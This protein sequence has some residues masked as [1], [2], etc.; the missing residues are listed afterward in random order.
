MSELT[1][2][3]VNKYIRIV[4]AS[5]C[6]L[7]MYIDQP[8]DDTLATQ[9]KN[10]AAKITEINVANSFEIIISYASLLVSYNPMNTDHFAVKNTIKS[11]IQLV[12]ESATVNKDKAVSKDAVEETVNTVELPVYYSTE[13]GPDLQR[14]AEHH[15]LTV[16]DVIRLHQQA[17]YRVFAIGFAPGFGYLGQVSEQIAMPR[18]S[19]PRSQV[20]KGAV[21]IADRQTAVYPAT[22]P[23]GWNIIGQCPVLMFDPTSTQNLVTGESSKPIMPFKVGDSVRFYAIDKQEYLALGGQL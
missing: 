2:A 23:G 3:T 5:E 16:E 15:N 1:L 12:L 13:C 20:P 11:A 17:T 10:I 6:S 4:P 18:L 22:S 7:I 14:I 9:L 19:T 8:L 21:A